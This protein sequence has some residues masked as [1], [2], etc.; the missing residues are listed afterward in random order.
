MAA[1]DKARADV[2]NTPQRR[3]PGTR[4]EHVPRAFDVHEHRDVARHTELVGRG[5]VKHFGH[6]GLPRPGR[7]PQPG[8]DDVA[9]DQLDAPTRVRLGQRQP[10]DSLR[11]QRRPARLD[12]T[13]RTVQ[14][15]I[16]QQSRKKRR[17]EESGES[18]KEEN[19]HVVLHMVAQASPFAAR[20]AP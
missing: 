12:K 20:A 5:E 13:D 11:G 16:G 1:A 7:Q 17:A 9:F 15:P 8:F 10:A 19:R 3:I 6:L 14:R 18:G 2:V 4:L